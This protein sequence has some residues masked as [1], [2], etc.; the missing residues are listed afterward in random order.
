MTVVVELFQ[1][2]GGMMFPDR[3]T[4]YITA[5]EDRQYKEEKINCKLRPVTFT[6][7]PVGVYKSACLCALPCH[8]IQRLTI[9]FS[10]I[11][12]GWDNVYGFDMSCIRKVALTEPL[13][14][15]V[16]HKQVCTNSCILKVSSQLHTGNLF[17]L[18]CCH[19]SLE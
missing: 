15:S 16:D 11:L 2:E 14:D 4:L 10:L 18:M 8:Y 19:N 7:T 9:V 12:S 5:I 3:A 13:V 17:V 6:N 1:V